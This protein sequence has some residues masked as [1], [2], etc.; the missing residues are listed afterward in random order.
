MTDLFKAMLKNR[1]SA[2]KILKKLNGFVEFD[3]ECNRPYVLIADTHGEI[4]DMEISKFRLTEPNDIEIY[5]EKWEEWVNGHE[6]LS[7]T[8][9]N[10]YLALSS[11]YIFG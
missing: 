6:C 5:V 8:S 2:I 3:D 11:K 7:T 4:Y 9:N 10:I 1:T